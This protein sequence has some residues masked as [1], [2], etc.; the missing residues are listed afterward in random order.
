[1]ADDNLFDFHGIK[2]HVRSHEECEQA[3]YVVCTTADTPSPWPD[4]KITN[5]GIC[6]VPVQ[7]RPYMP[8]RPMKIC[9][10]CFWKTTNP[11]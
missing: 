8:E 6:G 9:I 2:V 4:N 11:N 7:Y 5:C 3:Q 10:E 1:M